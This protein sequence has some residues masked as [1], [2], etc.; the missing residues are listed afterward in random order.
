ML[1][2]PLNRLIVACRGLGLIKKKE[3]GEP[4]AL[5][6]EGD[7]SEF[8]DRLYNL[9]EVLES[10]TDETVRSHM[11]KSELAAASIIAWMESEGIDTEIPQI[12]SDYVLKDKKQKIPNSLAKIIHE[13]EQTLRL[14]GSAAP[15]TIK[16][17]SISLNKNK[18]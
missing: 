10:L 2:D 12:I 18:K 16:I 9:Y 5:I 4:G 3:R 15:R 17:S 7:R 1:N 8:P 13:R 6:I 11:I 14:M